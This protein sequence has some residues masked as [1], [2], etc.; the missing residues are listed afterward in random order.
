MAAI[1]PA[2]ANELLTAA[3]AAGLT[4]DQIRAIVDYSDLDNV[5]Y[6][7]GSGSQGLVRSIE[8]A[9]RRATAHQ[10]SPKQV[11]Y[12]MSLL[13]ERRVSG[14]GGGFFN[15]PTTRTEVAGLSRREASLYIDS[16][17]GEY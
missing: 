9:Q 10:A 6:M 11:D 8:D 15:G 1:G 7:S 4:D 17:T 12:I 13:D 2:R 5:Q 14:E 16:L 3:R